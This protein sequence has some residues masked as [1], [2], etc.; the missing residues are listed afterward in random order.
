MKFAKQALE[1]KLRKYLSHCQRLERDKASI[2]DALK[3]CKQNHISD[4]NVAGAVIELCDRLSSLE[5]ECDTLSTAQTH[6]SSDSVQT[7]RLREEN[8]QLQDRVSETKERLT[9]LTKLEAD[10]HSRLSK[11]QNKIAQ[12]SEERDQLRNKAESAKG[13]MASLEN[14]KI[15][16]VRYLEQENLQLMLDLKTTKKQLQNYKTELDDLR[17]KALDD[18]DNTEDFGSL[19]TGTL[20]DS[21]P[22]SAPKTPAQV[23]KENMG[24][25]SPVETEKSKVKGSTKKRQPLVSKLTR[26]S[27][28]KRVIGT[29]AGKTVGLGEAV[30]ANEDNTAECKQS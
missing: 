14:E 8:K 11:A 12:L 5:Q 23:D 22:K 3:S 26:S 17:M 30:P 6:A 13:N 16:Q 19:S 18:N 4:G 27:R 1:T 15:R 21:S 9:T 7:E 20:C 2:I 25:L 28:K 10:L 24:N 29:P